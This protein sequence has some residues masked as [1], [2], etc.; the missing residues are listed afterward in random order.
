MAAGG[1]LEDLFKWDTGGYTRMFKAK[2]LAW[3][4]LHIAIANNLE[5]AK[6][7]MMERQSKK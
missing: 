7:S 4:N 3:Y 2:V 1:T 6:S 5:D